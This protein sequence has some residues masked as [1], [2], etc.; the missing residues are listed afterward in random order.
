MSASF[1]ASLAL[2]SKRA[3]TLARRLSRTAK[4]PP[5]L[6]SCKTT[7]ATRSGPALWTASGRSLSRGSARHHHLAQ[8]ARLKRRDGPAH[9]GSSGR[10]SLLSGNRRTPGSSRGLLRGLLPLGELHAC[11]LVELLEL[12]LRNRHGRL[13][14]THSGVGSRP[15]GRDH[16]RGALLAQRRRHRT[17]TPLD[18]GARCDGQLGG[19]RSQPRG[20]LSCDS[21]V[22]LCER[23][24]CLPRRTSRSTER[25]L[26]L[27]L[28]SGVRLRATRGAGG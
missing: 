15:L 19:G 24:G 6:N 4:R 20:E 3:A 13:C 12:S 26:R 25:R 23:V 28:S 2:Y 16:K 18:G 21:A 5:S 11:G 22:A 14:G 8:L 1:L 27:G 9:L 10:R 7:E 17:A